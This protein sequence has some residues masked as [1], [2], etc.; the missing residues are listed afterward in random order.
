MQINNLGPDSFLAKTDIKHTYKIIP[1]N[2]VDQKLLGFFFNGRY[3][4]DK[5]LPMVY[6]QVAEYL[7]FL[8]WLFIG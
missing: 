7:K 8:V 5:T 4:Y 2:A 1:I 6:A 3:Y